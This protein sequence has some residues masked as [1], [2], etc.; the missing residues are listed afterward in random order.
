VT[1]P[2]DAAI[3]VTSAE[4]AARGVDESAEPPECKIYRSPYR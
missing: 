1:A 3:V 2:K 4:L